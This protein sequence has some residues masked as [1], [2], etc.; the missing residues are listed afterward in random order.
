MDYQWCI[1]CMRCGKN[2][3]A[4][5]AIY[6]EKEVICRWCARLKGNKNTDNPAKNMAG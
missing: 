5:K 2:E 6:T 1:I 4:G 3:I